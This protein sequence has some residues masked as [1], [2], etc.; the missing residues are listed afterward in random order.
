MRLLLDSHTVLWWLDEDGP[1]P[2]EVRD[3]INDVSNDVAV[4]VATVWELAIKTANGRLRTPDHMVELLDA[5][6]VDVLDVSASDALAAASLPPHHGDPF[7]RMV[8]AQA[9]LG[10]YTVVTAD[11]RFADYGVAVVSAR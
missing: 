11:R 2:L 5:Q 1:L 7:D 9:R 10:D 8:I 6:E 4:S 3:M